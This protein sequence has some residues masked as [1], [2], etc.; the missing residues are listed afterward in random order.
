[1]PYDVTQPPPLVTPNFNTPPAP[2][3][4]ITTSQ[5]FPR[6]E[7]LKGSTDFLLIMAKPGT[8]WGRISPYAADLKNGTL[9]TGVRKPSQI[10]MVN[11]PLGK[12]A[13]FSNADALIIYQNGVLRVMNLDG[14]GETIKVSL[15]GPGFADL[16]NKTFILKPGFEIVAGQSPLGRSD[17]RPGD[18]IARKTAQLIGNK[19]VAVNQFS[20]E[21]VLKNSDLIA[22]LEQAQTGAKERRM[23]SDMSKMAGVLNQ[24]NG[25]WGFDNGKGD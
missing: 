9:L 20:L 18:G 25:G 6:I 2:L 8:D 17:M 5:N 15:E 7:N 24:V 11:T 16:D 14:T 21:S 12:I 19:H 13:V 23:F 22:Q 1:M 10:G 3:T 4:G